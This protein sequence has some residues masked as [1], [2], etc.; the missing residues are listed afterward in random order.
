M[1]QRWL[2]PHPLRDR[3]RASGLTQADLAERAGVS[4]QLIAAVEAGQNAPSVDAALRLAGALATTVEDLF[5]PMPPRVVPALGQR[6]REGR[7]LRVGRVG[8]QLVAAELADHGIAGAAWAR[9]DG[10]IEADELLLFDNA[11]PARFVLAGC[12]PALGIAEAMLWGRNE[13]GLL[14]LPAPTGVA[15][16]ALAAGRIHAAVVHGPE[17]ALGEPPVSALR[18]HLARWQVGI[19]HP[20]ELAFADLAGLLD[21][22]VAVVQREAEAS[23]QQ[24]LER[25]LRRLGHEQPPAGPKAP[26][27]IEA[28]RTAAILGCGALTTESAARAFGL[29]FLALEQHAVQ[30]WVADPWTAQPGF[31]AFGDVLASSAFTSRVAQFG[32]YELAGCGSRIG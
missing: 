13:P 10:R 18:L 29:R 9:P 7:P 16:S 11:A 23:S 24:A 21:S 28:A 2:P 4:R 19:A 8:D 25:A 14:A 32:G 26:G 17:E 31:A 6:L 1:E 27:H 22:G 15:L 3:R 5:A 12:D 30:V 20:P